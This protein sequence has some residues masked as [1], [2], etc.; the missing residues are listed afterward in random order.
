MDFEY[1]TLNHVPTIFPTYVKNI[2]LLVK[3]AAL[4]IAILVITFSSID[5]L[6]SGSKMKLIW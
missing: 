4:K 5:F 6:C 1:E 2:Y 3:R